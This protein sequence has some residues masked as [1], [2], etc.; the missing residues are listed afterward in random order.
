MLK[1]YAFELRHDG[2][3]YFVRVQ[4]SSIKEAK[5]LV[6]SIETC[7]ESAI[8]WAHRVAPTSKMGA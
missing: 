4:A 8:E 5:K 2:G 1:T 7:P 3:H 6:M